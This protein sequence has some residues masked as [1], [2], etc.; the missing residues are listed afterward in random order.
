MP[1][2]PIGCKDIERVPVYPGNNHCSVR[3][4]GPVV[5]GREGIKKLF[6]RAVDGPSTSTLGEGP[7]T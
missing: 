3:E 2:R 7:S 4:D 1:D 6:V 5:L